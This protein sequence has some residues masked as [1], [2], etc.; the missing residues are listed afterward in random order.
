MARAATT[1]GGTAKTF[2]GTS[3]TSFQDALEKAVASALR[4]APGADQTIKWTLKSASGQAG[5]IAPSTQYRVA[6]EATFD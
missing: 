2:R 4:A 3:K 1:Y 6:I 5:G